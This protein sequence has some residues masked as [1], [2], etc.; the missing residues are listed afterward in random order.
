[1]VMQKFIKQHIDDRGIATITLNRADVHNAFNADLIAELDNSFSTLGK[2]DTVRAII[3]TGAGKSFSAGADLNWMKKAANSSQEDNYEDA[4]RLS[5][6]LYTVYQCPKPT[7][8]L[9]NGPAFGGGVGL[10]ACCDIAIA[11]RSAAF[12]LSEVKLG[13]APSTISPFVIEAMGARTCKRLFITAERFTPEKAKFWGLV[14]EVASDVDYAQA[15][16]EGLISNI[17]AGGPHA[18]ASTK[19]LIHS[20]A[21]REID[22]NLRQETARHIAE[23]R[24]S[25][26]GKEGLEAFL[27]KRPP[28][29]VKKS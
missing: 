13:L 26:E 4:L 17:L 25:E 3:L 14:S 18:Q 6:M 5:N 7:I 11:V 15:V 12:S 28:N 23:R 29:W 24:A 8:A 22:T 19:A 1:M 10:V 2:N 21:G 20:I 9:V 16:I 27:G